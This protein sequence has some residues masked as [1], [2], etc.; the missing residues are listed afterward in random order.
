MVAEAA[1]R[2]SWEV[3]HAVKVLVEICIAD[4][5]GVSEDQVSDLVG[6]L[7]KTVEDKEFQ[8]LIDFC[9]RFFRVMQK[10]SSIAAPSK[11]SASGE[12]LSELEA[13]EADWPTGPAED[14]RDD[15]EDA[16]LGQPGALKKVAAAKGK[17]RNWLQ[18]CNAKSTK[19]LQKLLKA[20]AAVNKD[21]DPNA[22]SKFHEQ[23]HFP[24]PTL[25][26]RSES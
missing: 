18:A 9:K 14:L 13:L 12:V 19:E 15:W 5:G 24:F 25:D 26:N 20:A 22:E 10:A 8:T 7:P 4:G 3:L 21:L 16:G 11:A 17:V 2:A 1:K 23:M 6:K